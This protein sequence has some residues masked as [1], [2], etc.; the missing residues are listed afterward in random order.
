MAIIRRRN[1]LSLLELFTVILHV[2]MRMFPMR[3]SDFISGAV[4][5]KDGTTSS[6]P[7][8]VQEVKTNEHG[9][10][11]VQL[12][13]SVSKRVKRINDV[14]LNWLEAV[15]RI[16]MRWPEYHLRM[17]SVWCRESME[18]MLFQLEFSASSH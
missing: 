3:S 16:A 11:E 10:F 1:L 15:S 2:S 12:P 17:H 5:C 7:S 14:R 18:F 6:R 4:E 9:E 8:F 13:F